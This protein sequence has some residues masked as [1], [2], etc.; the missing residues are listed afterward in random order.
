[1]FNFETHL[2]VKCNLDEVGDFSAICS[3]I[4]AK[5][6]SVILSKCNDSANKI[7]GILNEIFVQLDY[8]VD[9]TT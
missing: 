2:T 6:I 7:E 3:A 8:D 5:A 1:M 9:F 4:G